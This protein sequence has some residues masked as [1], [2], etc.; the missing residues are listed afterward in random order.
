MAVFS[1]FDL[2]K[3]MQDKIVPEPNSGCWMWMAATNDGGYGNTTINGKRKY[4]HRAAYELLIGKIP[5]GLHIDHLCRVRS[6]CNPSHLEP[7]THQENHKRG[8]AGKYLADRTHCDKGHPFSGDNLVT[9]DKGYRRCHT[10]RL[11]INRKSAGYKGGIQE[12]MKT[13]CPKG[14]PY[15]GDN[16]VIETSGKKCRRCRICRNE[17]AM[18]RYNKKKAL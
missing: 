12:K 16:L 4:T 2:P 11:E 6:C 14:H 17:N 15:S 18:K 8:E 3:S 9:R 10:C 5:D 13:H 1:I 7:V